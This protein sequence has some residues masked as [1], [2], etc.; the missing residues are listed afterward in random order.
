MVDDKDGRGK[1]GAENQADE[2]ESD[3]IEDEG[4]EN[5]DAEFEY[6]GEA[7]TATIR[8][9]EMHR[10]WRSIRLER[11]RRERINLERGIEKEGLGVG[12]AWKRQLGLFGQ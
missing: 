9:L 2:G 5:Q 11:N 4:G 10:S 3:G 7:E 8:T 6:D 12:N 1:D